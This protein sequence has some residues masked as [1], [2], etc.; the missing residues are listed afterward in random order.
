MY[1]KAC[2]TVDSVR[3]NVVDDVVVVLHDDVD[4]GNKDNT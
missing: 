4:V 3:V 1:D 2:W